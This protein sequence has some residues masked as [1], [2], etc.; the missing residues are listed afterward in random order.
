MR[1]IADDNGYLLEVSFGAIIIYND[2]S[3]TEYTGGVP[4]GYDNLVDWFAKEGD[5]LHRWHIV[6]GELTLDENAPEPE[7]YV[8]PVAPT[9]KWVPLWE[10]AS[11]NSVFSE[12][13]MTLDLSEYDFLF[14]EFL[15]HSS[16]G[17]WRWYR[18]T[19]TV[20]VN[21]E[22]GWKYYKAVGFSETASYM[23]FR[24][25]S[26]ANNTLRFGRGYYVGSYGASSTS[27]S[28]YLYVPLKIYGIKGAITE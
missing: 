7:V 19:M 18:V 5:K 10:N 16:S 20:P 4:S 14:M 12:Q 24:A 22:D 23:A 11:P 6:E 15:T 26:L 28:D 17:S 3:C 9:C 1:Y 2:C 27:I 21:H 25:F 8:P 13:T